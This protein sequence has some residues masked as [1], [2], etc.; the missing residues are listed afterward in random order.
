MKIDLSIRK[1]QNGVTVASLAKHRD[2]N[3]IKS[4]YCHQNHVQFGIIQVFTVRINKSYLSLGD[5]AKIAS[6]FKVRMFFK[7]QFCEIF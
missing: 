6:N 3:K 4:A 2:V 7:I 1:L 5:Q